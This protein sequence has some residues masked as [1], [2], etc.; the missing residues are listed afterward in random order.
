MFFSSSYEDRLTKVLR[1]PPQLKHLSHRRRSLFFGDLT[2]L[3]EIK[4]CILYV[5]LRMQRMVVFQICTFT[6]MYAMLILS[7]ERGGLWYS[8]LYGVPIVRAIR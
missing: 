4:A 8:F 3:V 6:G 1:S 5:P 2:L 7:L